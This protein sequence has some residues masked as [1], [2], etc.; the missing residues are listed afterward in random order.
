M[1]DAYPTPFEPRQISLRHHKV[2]EILGLEL[3][4]EQI[5]GYLCQLGLKVVGRKPR[6]VD[7]E[8][9]KPDPVTFRVPTF[10]VDLKREVDLTEEVARLH[11][12][13]KI[14]A[15][16]PRGAV[17]ANAYDAVH[18]VLGEARRILSGLGLSEAQ[19][20]TLISD[21]SAR[22]AAG[23]TLVPLANPLSSDMNVLRPSLLPGLLDTLRHNLSHKN[24]D[25]ALFELGRVFTAGTSSTGAAGAREQRRIAIALT[26]RRHPLFWTGDGREARFDIH[27]L[28]GFIEEFLEQ[29]GV[30]GI[31]YSRRAEST[32]LFLESATV[33]LGKFPLG[34]MGQLL[35]A[36]GKHY[37]LRDAVL[38]AELNLDTL[39]ARRNPAKAFRALPAFP[40]VRRDVALLVPETTTHETVLQ[41]VKQSK[42]A[43]LESADLFD[44]FRGKNVPAGQKSMAYA[45]TYRN[46]ERT[47]TDAEVNA[48]QEKLVLQLKQQLQA[49]VREG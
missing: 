39:L 34:E 38:L 8:G 11:G 10:R 37:D 6:P 4:P 26:G 14:P 24:D 21:A 23:D 44:V 13:D 17:G 25:V 45:L 31:S 27:D 9:A 30:R 3:S 48:A 28:K 36:L 29:F 12:V 49:V 2:N 33:H 16:A 35:P 15:T 19:G 1:V 41:V 43:N 22:L 46:A 5:E 18:D 47:L 7:A 40:T 32:P 42:P 20:Q